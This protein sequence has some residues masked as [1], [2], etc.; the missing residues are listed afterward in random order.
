MSTLINVFDGILKYD[1]DEIIIIID[2]KNDVWFYG[3]QIVKI[4]E[5]KNTNAAINEKVNK[6]NRITYYEI[7]EYAKKRYNIQDHS[8]FINEKGLYQLVLKSKMKKAYI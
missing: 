1:N 7:K 6:N 3:K 8:S 4:L 2:N 5:Y